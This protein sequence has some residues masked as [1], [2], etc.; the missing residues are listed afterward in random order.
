MLLFESDKLSPPEVSLMNSVVEML[1]KV[2]L[3][4]KVVLLGVGEEL[5]DD[6]PSCCA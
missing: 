4:K 5:D 3:K 2:S 1:L 6:N